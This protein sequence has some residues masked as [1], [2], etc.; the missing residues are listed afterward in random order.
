MNATNREQAEHWNNTEEVGHWIDQQARHDQM[1]EPFIELLIDGAQLGAGDQV[2]DIGCG[3]GATTIAAARVV[4]PGTV[5]GVDLSAPMLTQARD[6]A[7]NMSVGNVTFQQADAQTHPFDRYGFTAI[8]SRF[9]IMFFDD[10]VA[11]FT[12]IHNAA[13]PDAG[14]AFVCWQPLTANEWLLVPG[15]ALA[16]H[17]PLPDVG[18]PGAPGMFAFADADQTKRV[19]EAAGW[20]DITAADTHT[21]IYV[22]GH[23]TV[24]DAVEFLRTGSLGRTMLAGLDPDTEARVVDAVR[25][26]LAAH[27]DGTGVRL[28][29]AVW[30]ITALA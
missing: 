28:D 4:T 20:H 5:L 18:E 17:A 14:L 9:G 12:N 24:D 23:G 10:P 3:C 19:L 26:A 6:D 21:P 1:L 27:H 22:G 8:I 11:A 29:A 30:L 15:A 25:T 7:Q 16:Q 2:L 13:R